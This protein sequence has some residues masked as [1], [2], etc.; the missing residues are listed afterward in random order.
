MLRFLIKRMGWMVLTMWLV[1]TAS[2]FL[3]RSVPGGPFDDERS[4]PPEIEQNIKARYN[5]DASLWEQYL[6]HLGR[7]VVFDF[8]P[9]YRLED[10]TVTVDESE[11]P[12][13]VGLVRIVG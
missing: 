9:S 13:G 8:G 12:S 4:L 10:Y 5:L 2:F 1:F 11:L 3:M 7:V 6:D